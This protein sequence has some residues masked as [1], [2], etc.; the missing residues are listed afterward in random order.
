MAPYSFSERH[1]TDEGIFH[2]GE[3]AVQERADERAIARRRE[4]M[5]GDRLADGARALL[6]QQG[7]A[8]G[9]AEAS[10]GALWASMWC[11]MPGFV[12]SRDDGRSVEINSALH[13]TL[14]VD[15]VRRASRTDEPLGILVI[16]LATR[17]RMRINGRV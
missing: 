3:I 1:V 4:T 16:D 7:V 17:R 2:A 8:A 5:I 15:P 10:D 14:A 13:D 12:S 6:G 11:G 9:A